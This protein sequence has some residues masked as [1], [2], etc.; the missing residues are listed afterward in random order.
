M[1]PAG[2]LAYGQPVASARGH[3]QETCWRCSGREASLSVGSAGPRGRG[4]LCRVTVAEGETGLPGH[5]SPLRAEAA[6][7]PLDL[8]AVTGIWWCLGDREHALSA[9]HHG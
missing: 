4:R 9:N 1:T 5:V 2:F 3:S 6:L 7:Q 8:V